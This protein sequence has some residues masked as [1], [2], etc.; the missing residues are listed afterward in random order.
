MS[1]TM[2]EEIL[3]SVSMSDIA[4]RLGTDEDTAR[5]ATEAA[6]PTLLAGLT[7]QASDPSRALGLAAAVREDHDGDLLDSDDPIG[8]VDPDEGD[9]I[10]G[11]VFGERRGGVEQELQGFL[12][13]GSGDLV[14]K[15][16]PMLAPLVMAYMKKKMTGGGAGGGGGL[17]DL[18]GSVLGGGAA[19]QATGGGGGLGDLLGS[20]L[21]GGDAPAQDRGDGGGIGDILGSVLGGGKKDDD[22]Q[23]GGVLDNVLDGIRDKQKTSSPLDDI[24]GS[25]L[26]RR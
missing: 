1:R 23:G 4:A 14:G 8:R 15:L 11:H 7:A 16:M 3:S 17:G 6:L 2:T 13:G 12:G 26:G 24:L 19:G 25:I 10:V 5:Q 22:A 18:L 9:R 20:V 21:G